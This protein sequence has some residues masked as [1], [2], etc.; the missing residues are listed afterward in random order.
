MYIQITFICLVSQPKYK[1]LL[2]LKFY[3]KKRLEY[4]TIV[5]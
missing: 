3:N 1:V 5:Q 4:I 2:D